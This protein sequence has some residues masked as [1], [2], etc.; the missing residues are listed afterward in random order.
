MNKTVNLIIRNCSQGNL[1]AG[2][3]NAGFAF[4]LFFKISKD[5]FNVFLLSISNYRLTSE[6]IISAEKISL[7]LLDCGSLI[8]QGCDILEMDL[9]EK[10]WKLGTGYLKS[11]LHLKI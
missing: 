2:N 8:C 7:I 6:L 3:S 1:Y 4:I 10:C 5:Y 11:L 9:L